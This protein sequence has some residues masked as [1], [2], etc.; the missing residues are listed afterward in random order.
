MIKML[1]S[2]KSYGVGEI[3]T[4]SNAFEKIYV[5]KGIAEFY[6]ESDIKNMK[7]TEIPNVIEK[8]AKVENKKELKNAIQ[9]PSN[10]RRN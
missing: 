2:Y 6:I 1:K 3:V 4:G 5:K 7:Q 10:K 9:K 8:K